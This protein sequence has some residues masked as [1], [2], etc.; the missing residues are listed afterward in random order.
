MNEHENFDD[1]NNDV[2]APKK[3]NISPL[4]N[5]QG[6]VK[7]HKRVPK[8]IASNISLILS[9]LVL[10]LIVWFIIYIINQ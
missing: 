3:V 4:P 5:Q 6:I 9:I 7:I 1:I 10:G 8:F 2:K